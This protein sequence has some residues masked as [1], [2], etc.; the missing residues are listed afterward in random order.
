MPAKQTPLEV[1]DRLFEISVAQGA[2]DLHLVA[3]KPPLLR[4]AGLLMPV[5]GSRELTGEV[6][7]DLTF[8]L[9]TDQERAKFIADKELDIA[10]QSPS[11]QRFRVNVSCEKTNVTMV[12]RTIPSDIPTLDSLDMPEIIKKM[13][14]YPHGLVLVTGPTG[15]GKSTTLAAMMNKINQTEPVNIITLEDPIEFLFVPDKAIIRQRQFGQDFVS[16]TEA[17]KHILRQDP[18]V[19]MVGEMRDAE[20]IATTLTIAETG[21]LVFA[22]LHTYSA[23]Q[24]IDRIIDAM[25]PHQQNQIRSQLALSLR[26]V[27]S[28]QLLPKV[29]GGRVAARE[30]LVNNSACANLIR[31]SQIAQI[32]NVLQ[33]SASEGMTTL[34]QDL[35]RMIGAGLITKETAQQY[36]VGTDKNLT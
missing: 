33:T 17:L 6:V 36:I 3:N 18:D 34:N 9:M 11:G 13:T 28:Q 12:A 31:E 14:E 2:S 5:E 19:V 10:H 15:S 16:F 25:P 22:T 20:T 1:M 7:R 8:S 35:K 32:K 26:A 23:A 29:G 21:H 30:I 27:V 4:I 24:T